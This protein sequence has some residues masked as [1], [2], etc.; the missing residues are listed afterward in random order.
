ML[1][2]QY[3]EEL[4]KR[5]DENRESYNSDIFLLVLSFNLVHYLHGLF[6]FKFIY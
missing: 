3:I 2:I 1:N 4:V 5:L 6:I